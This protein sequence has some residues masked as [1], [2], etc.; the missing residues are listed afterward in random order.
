MSKNYLKGLLLLVA[1]MVT[2]AAMA[3]DFP[4]VGKTPTS[5]GKYVL[6]SYVNPNNYF[7][8]TSWD[9]AYYLLPYA[10]SHFADHAFTA[11]KAS[12]GSWYFSVT[13]TTQYEN[14]DGTVDTEETTNYLGFHE[15]TNDNLNA[16]LGYPAYFALEAAEVDG[17]YRLRIGGEHGNPSVEGLC[18]HL[19]ST[20][21]YLVASES[22]C[23]W[24]PDVWG[25]VEKAIDDA[26]YE[27]VVLDENE[28]C[29]PLDNRSELWAFAD[30]DE[31]P[32]LKNKLELYSLLADVENTI[33]NLD[34]DTFKPGFQGVLD[35]VTPVY[36]KDEVSDDDV[37][38]AKALVQAKQALYNQIRQAQQTLESEPDAALQ[39]AVDKAISDFN[40][41]NTVDELKAAQEAL[42]AALRDHDMGQGDLTRMGQNMSFEDLSSQGG[43]TTSSVADV[44]VGWNLYI[45]GRQVQTAD[46]IRAAGI[47]AWAGINGDGSGMKDGQMIYGIWNQGIPEIELSQ[48]ISGL[49]TGTYIV[50]AAMMVGA[51]GNGS[52]RTTQR[53]FGNLN[54][55]FFSSQ[56]GYNEA[57]LDPQ[58]VWSYEGLDEPV[59]DTELQEMSV[60]A[61]VFD[62]T[63]TFGL[64]TNGDITAA[65]RT[66]P[67]GAGGDGWFKV[68]NFRILKEGYVQD[69][70]LAIYDHF[71]DALNEMLRDQMQEDVS[72]EASDLLDKTNCNQSSTKDE[73]VAAIKALMEVMP[74]V[75]SSVDAYQSL[76]DAIDQAYENL[77]AYNNYA[78]AGE[79]NDL[80]M[81]AED[82][83]AYGKANEEDI[84]A[85]IKRLDD[86]F[87]ELKLSGVAVGIYVTELMKNPGFE[88]LSAQGGVDTSGSVNPP[89]GWDLF[90][91]GEQQTSAPPLGWCGINGGDDISSAGIVDDEGNPVTKQYVEG[92]H[93][94]GIWNGSIPNV[95]LSQTLTGLPNGT[96]VLSANVMVQYQWAGNCLTTQRLFANDCVQ[97][98]GTE[99][100]HAVNLTEDAHAANK[101]GHL[102]YAG[103]TCTAD[104]P[105][106]N[107]L[108]PMEVRFYVTD[109]TAKVGFRT[110]NINPDGS[111]DTS[112][113]HGWF[114]LDNFQLFYESEEIPEGIE[115][116]SE[117]GGS[118]VSQRFF[119]TDGRQQRSLSRGVNIVESRMSDGTVKTKKVVVK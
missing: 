50:Q 14:E 85:M 67:N 71:C 74:K 103:Y 88:D 81:E 26:G 91:D 70:A 38:A 24:F 107:T 66:E 62:G 4:K 22:S 43:N 101:N 5:G 20:G 11:T 118:I 1:L 23:P 18:L 90:L 55:K 82:M 39:A 54:V 109:G 116:I 106:T 105:Y 45:N 89:A 51:N 83:Y 36:S 27:Y 56:G 15:P 79:F 13:T 112:T 84:A 42:A 114:K 59:T 53:I 58:E 111:A 99:E 25:G 93:L 100:E 37:A 32:A 47:N 95:E 19:N 60:R 75:K 86:G 104:D 69:D 3:V 9:G 72:K 46:N 76:Q 52:R 119:S 17:F 87:Q 49:E 98:F 117:G 29:V 34:D 68:D 40:T 31:L 41:K 113:G 33:A 97:M 44:P 28:H 73:I 30:P 78:G 102:T 10:D 35:A 2:S 21:Q 16:K 57:L 64:R 108:R 7:S 48:T 6:V 8:R 63:L 94:W 77:Y 96:Y 115:A 65:N 92:T 12:N 80:I 110:N 61:F